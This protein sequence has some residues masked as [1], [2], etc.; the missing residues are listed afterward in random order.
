M[1]EAQGNRGGAARRAR[2]PAAERRETILRAA[3]AVFGEAG[4]RAA[5]VS[6]VA[7]RVGV[8]EPV[9]FQNFG[10]KAELFAAVLERAAAEARDSLDDLAASPGPASG[11]LAHVLARPP[12]H[13]PGGHA[14]PRDAEPGDAEPGDAEP[15][16]AGQAGTGPRDAGPAGTGHAGERHA[17]AVFGVLFADAAALAA[18]PALAGPARAALA[19]VATH[20]A[21][22]VRHAQAGGGVHPGADPEAAAWLLLSVLSA[23]RLRDA[24][25]PG[26]LEPA[27]TALALRALALPGPS[28]AL[29]TG[30]VVIRHCRHPALSLT[31]T[32]VNRRRRLGRAAGLGG[33]PA[34][35][36]A[37]A[38]SGR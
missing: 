23:R 35:P 17:G 31:G 24:A 10:S 2:L 21:D 16:D 30:T 25:M 13:P 11:L 9:I 19:T 14:A 38:R 32:V 18:E 27:V 15:G 5:R 20:L 8:S 28:S 22:L 26:G 1:T 4:Y 6:D 37:A 29:L 33:A 3:M 34:C 12:A 36:P 7:A